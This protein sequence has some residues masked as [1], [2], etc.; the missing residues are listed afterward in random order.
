MPTNTDTV[1]SVLSE[2]IQRYATVAVDSDNEVGLVLHWMKSDEEANNGESKGNQEG[3]VL[4]LLSK[5]FALPNEEI[6]RTYGATSQKWTLE[7]V[8]EVRAIFN[9]LIEYHEKLEIIVFRQL[10]PSH[11]LEHTPIIPKT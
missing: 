2:M 10:R 8:S 3:D 5:T 6:G 1:V 9:E 11:P 4:R 7:V